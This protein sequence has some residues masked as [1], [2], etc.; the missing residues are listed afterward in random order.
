[1]SSEEILREIAAEVFTCSKCD[2]CK[3]RTKAVPGE[4]NAQAKIILACAFPSPGTAFVRPLQRSH[5]EQ[6]NTSAAI[7]LSISSDD[8]LLYTSFQMAVGA[9]FI[10]PAGW[11]GKPHPA[12]A[13]NRAPTLV[14]LYQRR[15]GGRGLNPPSR[16]GPRFGPPGPPGPVGP[17]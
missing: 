13:I 17:P 16:R 4:G 7:S 3:G 10:A 14:H 9:R 5:F 6:V 1:M 11:G 15:S 12:G 8:I 2:L